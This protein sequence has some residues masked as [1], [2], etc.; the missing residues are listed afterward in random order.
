[1][2]TWLRLIFWCFLNVVCGLLTTKKAT[3]EGCGEAD[4]YVISVVTRPSLHGPGSTPSL[5]ILGDFERPDLL[6]VH[7]GR[8]GPSIRIQGRAAAAELLRVAMRMERVSERDLAAALGTDVRIAH[9][10]RH[11]RPPFAIGDLIVLSRRLPRL[12]EAV[13]SAFA[14]MEGT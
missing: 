11:S 12:A 7:R 3:N 6:T 9:G 10:M 2:W 8:P 1:M 5:A 14:P 4:E 13:L